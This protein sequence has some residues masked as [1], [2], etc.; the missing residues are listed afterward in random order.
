MT[1]VQVEARNIQGLQYAL[2]EPEAMGTTVVGGKNKAG[3]TSLLNAIAW[4]LGGEK[5]CP[6]HPIREGQETA[7]CSVELTADA[8]RM[9][10]ACK[11]TRKWKRTKKGEEDS[12][13]SIRTADGFAAPSPQSILDTI[14][15]TL[16][17]E[18]EKFLRASEKEQVKILRELVG[19][20]FTKLD[21]EYAQLYKDRTKNNKDVEAARVQHEAKK[22]HADAPEQPVSVTALME[23]LK[24]R[25]ADTKRVNE[26]RLESQN[27]ENAGR[28]AAEQLIRCESAL[29]QATRDRDAAIASLE[30]KRKAADTAKLLADAVVFPNVEEIRKQITDADETNRKQRENAEKA[31][32]RATHEKLVKDSE[33]ATNRLAKILE[34]KHTATA[35]AKWPIEGLGF[36]DDGVTFH[37]RQFQQASTME[38]IKTAVAIRAALAPSLQFA[39]IRDGSLLDDEQLALLAAFAAEKNLQLFIERVGAGTECDIV[40][41]DGRIVGQEEPP[42]AEPEKPKIKKPPGTLL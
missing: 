25:E 20:D 37:G 29:L 17:F 24:T 2:V 18:P 42:A 28:E 41:S 35:A 1:I 11:V 10:P 4:T 38:Q 23:E 6:E 16:G 21:E 32:L 5:L 27:A 8:A 12:V 34:E 26:I 13:L 22:F 39:F 3:K 36:N 31:V 9:F 15:G 14:I 30:E 19:L 33:W 40:I 7:E